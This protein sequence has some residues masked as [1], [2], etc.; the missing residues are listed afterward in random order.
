MIGANGANGSHWN[1]RNW[2]R[3]GLRLA[4]LIPTTVIG[5]N[6]QFVRSFIG[7]NSL[8]PVTPFSILKTKNKI[9]LH[10]MKL[11]VAYKLCYKINFRCKVDV[12]VS[13]SRA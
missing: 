10:K 4:P 6:E 3:F 1:Q 12:F 5:A 13:T 8:A 2:R 9:D 11:Q 7:A